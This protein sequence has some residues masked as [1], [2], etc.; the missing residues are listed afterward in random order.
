MGLCVLRDRVCSNCKH[1]E[2]DRVEKAADYGSIICPNC[3]S[4]S[5]NSILTAPSYID[6]KG[7]GWTPNL[8][9]GNMA[10]YWAEREKSE[11]IKLN[12]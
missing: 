4:L 9:K 8:S 10:G 11:T 2:I 12:F 1:V 7:E 6:F 3:Q 5:F